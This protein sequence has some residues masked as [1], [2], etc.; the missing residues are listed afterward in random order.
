VLSYRPNPQW[1]L[2]GSYS[3]GYKA[4]GFNLDRS[5][6]GVPIF[7]PTDSRNFG[8][9]G[10]P[11]GTGN[12][13]FDAEIVDAF[14]LGFKYTRRNFI[15]NVAAFRQ[16]FSDFQLNTFNG[17]VF[18]VQNVNGCA[19]DLGT[20]VF[21]GITMPADQDPSTGTG[22]CAQD[23][24]EYGVTSTG[25]ELEAA[26]YPRRDLSFSGGMTYARTRYRDDLVGRN[27]GTPLDP[28]LFLLPGER[29]SNAPEFVITS[30]M[31]FTPRIGDSGLSALFYVD[32]RTSSNYNTGSDLFPEKEQTSFTLVN[33]RLGIRGPQQRWALELWAQ[34]VFNIDY[35]QV[36]FNS[37]F[38]GT[39]SRAHVQRWGAAQPGVNPAASGSPANQLFSSFLAEPRTFGVTGRFR[40]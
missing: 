12:L 23:D 22:A 38:Q 7:S 24:V 30:S 19:A 10:A 36:A 31:T 17:S 20:S 11:F 40:F 1:L 6:L 13:Q 4:G 39:N 16:Q 14:E 28:S 25:V 29:L 34:N 33:A 32:Q 18:I 3:R 35:Q 37:P 8:S 27:N 2:Y 5:A 21:N 15:F 26:I 9:R